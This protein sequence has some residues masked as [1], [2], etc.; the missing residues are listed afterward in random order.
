[1]TA[2]ELIEDIFR[3]PQRGVAGN[4][5]RITMKQLVYL[6]DLIG[7]DEEGAAVKPGRG[8]SLVWM[9]SGRT[10]FVLTEDPTGGDKHTITKYM[11][12]VPSG[13]GELFPA[14]VHGTGN[15]Q[16]ETGG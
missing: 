16:Q 4:E 6:R 13:A 7:Q 10:K 9:P 3:R 15:R 14:E 12:L 8:L 1:M 5:R 2:H 11:N